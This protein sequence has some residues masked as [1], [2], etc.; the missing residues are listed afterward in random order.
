MNPKQPFAA[1]QN[2]AFFRVRAASNAAAPSVAAAAVA[3][4]SAITGTSAVSAAGLNRIARTVQRGVVAAE[5][6]MARTAAAAE[7]G[8]A[9]A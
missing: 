6:A 8:A 2:P 7:T 1:D 9:V 3:T 4:S 5:P